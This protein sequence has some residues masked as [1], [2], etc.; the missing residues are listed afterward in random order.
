MADPLHSL[1][2]QSKLTQLPDRFERGQCV[3]S[4]GRSLGDFFSLFRVNFISRNER[5]PLKMK[6]ESFKVL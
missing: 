1:Q 5:K 3:Q 2:G 6:A 4:Q